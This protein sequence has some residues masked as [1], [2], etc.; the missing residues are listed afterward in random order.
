MK[1]LSFMDKKKIK[2][3]KSQPEEMEVIIIEWQ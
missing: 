1:I 3:F 2:I